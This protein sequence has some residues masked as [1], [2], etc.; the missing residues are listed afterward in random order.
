MMLLRMNYDPIK[1]YLSK[2][3]NRWPFTRKFFYAILDF[4][5]LRTWH[6]H[7]E[8]KKHAR[9]TNYSNTVNVLDAGS[10][11]GQY[12]YFMAKNFPAWQIIGVDVKKDEI[13]SCA[14]FFKSL[15][16]KRVLFQEADLTNFKKERAFEIILSVD[17]MEHIEDDITVFENFYASLKD[18]GLLLINTPSDQGGSDAA[19]TGQKGFIG[20]HVRNGY[21]KKEIEEKLV[22]AG[23]SK[24]NTRYTYG[25]PGNL[26]WRLT[27]KFP[28]ACLGLSKIFV[29]LL[30]FYFALVLPLIIVLNMV[31]L[32]V[33]HKSGTGLLVKAY[34]RVNEAPCH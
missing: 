9:E 11:Y 1:H 30:P 31:D 14:K 25:K 27:M 7:R 24:V 23:F 3:F 32:N 26:S 12:T 8:L 20:E 33:K 29:L 15:G 22:R 5:L 21:S 19:A 34:K 28:M 10:G 18:N 16:I 2:N 4:F 6:I 17:V 13:D